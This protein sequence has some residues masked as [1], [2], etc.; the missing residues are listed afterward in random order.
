MGTLRTPG[1]LTPGN[2]VEQRVF[3]VSAGRQRL[4]ESPLSVQGKGGSE[5]LGVLPELMQ[6]A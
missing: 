6:I 4:G 2:Q 5:G 1:L 3:T